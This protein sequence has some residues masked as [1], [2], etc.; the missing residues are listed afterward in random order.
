[1]KGSRARV[2]FDC[3]ILLQALAFPEGPAGRCLLLVEQGMVELF[4]SSATLDE[5][6]T[7]LAYE[8][9]RTISPNLTALNIA[10]FL[11]RLEFRATRVRRVR[12]VIEHPRDPADEPYL[13]LAVAASADYLISRDKDL[14]SL[15]TSHTIAS[16]EFRQRAH[17]LKILDP[18]E[19]LKIMKD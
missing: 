8:E 11:K 4:V 7:V 15:M 10:A 9:V 1:M 19:F 14:L 6:K 18:V 17:P 12:H 16:K 13:D 2:V 5:L 3:N